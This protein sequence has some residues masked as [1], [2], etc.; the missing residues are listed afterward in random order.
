MSL[1]VTPSTTTL[2]VPDTQQL[3][4]TGTYSD[5]TMRNVTATVTWSSSA[6]TVATV[7]AAGVVTAAADGMATLTAALDGKTATAVITVSGRRSRRSR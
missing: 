5:G 1:A 6:M 3:T 4:A 7:T 2:G